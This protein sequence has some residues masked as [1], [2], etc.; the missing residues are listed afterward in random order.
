MIVWICVIYNKVLNIIYQPFLL[1]DREVMK[2]TIYQRKNKPVFYKKITREIFR[3][4][5]NL[6][7][8]MFSFWIRKN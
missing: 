8:L 1:S 2:T 7:K 4:Y 3:L 5:F 6:Y